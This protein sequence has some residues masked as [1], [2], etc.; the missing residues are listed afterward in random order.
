MWKS[1]SILLTSK[2]WTDWK[3]SFYTGLYSQSYGFSSGHVWM[4]ELDCEE[5]WVLKN[6]YFRTVVL[7][8]T[9]ESPLDCKIKPVNPKGNQSW[10]FIRRTDAEVEAPVLSQL[11]RRA[12]S[13]EKTLMLRK[14]EGR[15]R[16]WQRT[17]SLDGI[18]DLIDM[19]LSKL[20]EMIEGQGRLAC[21]CP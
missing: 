8:K 9:L 18:P 15:R 10:I 17:K 2:S 6:W 19:S 7:E 4:R 12:D 3:F 13:L 21:C 20:W 1:N 11:M 16:G 5:S 14:F